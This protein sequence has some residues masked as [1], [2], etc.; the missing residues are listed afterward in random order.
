MSPSALLK[1]AQA[2]NL[3]RVKA[4]ES[5]SVGWGP[6]LPTV[7]H[8]RSEGMTYDW[9]YTWLMERDPTLTEERRNTFRSCLSSRITRLKQR[10]I[11]RA[12]V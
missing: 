10:E 11:G 1:E 4:E 12:H 2:V 5:V 8:F 3:V 6:Y 7:Q 9:I